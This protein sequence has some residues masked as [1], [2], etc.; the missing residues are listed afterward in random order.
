MTTF[1]PLLPDS[2]PAFNRR[3]VLAGTAG[4]AASA[5]VGKAAA[6]PEQTG[7]LDLD[8]KNDSLLALLKIQGDLSGADVIGGFPGKAWAWV[9]GE[10]NYLLFG[11]YGI[12]AS[13]IE[14]RPDEGGWR[15]Y[16]R[17]ILYY[18]DPQSGEVLD[19]WKNP[20]TDREVEVLHIINDPVHR[21]YSEKGSPFGPPFPY[22]ING[23]DIVF[24]IDVFRAEENPMPRADYP[25]HSQQEGYQVA[26]RG[27]C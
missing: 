16:H 23:D 6:Y 1:M 5:L 13:R 25:L 4:L 8:D 10:R 15:F 17:E 11:T 18:L 12:G 24:Q 3:A 20:M 9:P 21:F 27:G 14:Y 22:L 26:E 19:T 2:M 7:P